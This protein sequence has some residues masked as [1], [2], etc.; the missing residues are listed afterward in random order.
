MKAILFCALLLIPGLL[1]SQKGDTILANNLSKNLRNELNYYSLKLVSGKTT[2]SNYYVGLDI[3]AILRAINIDTQK[4]KKIQFFAN[5]S[6]CYELTNSKDT[7]F[8]WILQKK[9]YQWVDTIRISESKKTKKIELE[10]VYTGYKY[11]NPIKIIIK[12]EDLKEI[13]NDS[14]Y[15]VFFYTGKKYIFFLSRITKIVIHS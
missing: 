2:K 13:I 10:E 11:L 3:E 4:I 14:R 5:D 7:N 12:A 9:K 15:T 6:L 1:I 8:V